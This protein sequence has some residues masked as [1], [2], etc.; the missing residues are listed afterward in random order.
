MVDKVKV[1]AK[2]EPEHLGHRV[3]IYH[4]MKVLNFDQIY[5]GQG[6]INKLN[7]ATKIEPYKL[8]RLYSRT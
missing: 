6:V 2:S 5:I 4:K 1:A 3:G 7:V 8:Y